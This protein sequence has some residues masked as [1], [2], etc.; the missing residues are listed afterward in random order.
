MSVPTDDLRI[1]EIKPLSS[2]HE[3]MGE[4]PRTARASQSAAAA[5][6]AF[7]QILTGAD[8]RLTVVVVRGTVAL[9]GVGIASR[10]G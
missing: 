5:R 3:V 6:A 9:E 4:L 1:A 8:D 7:H 2:P 10:R